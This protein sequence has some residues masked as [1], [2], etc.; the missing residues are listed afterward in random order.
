[1]DRLED[2][3]NYMGD[4]GDIV[5]EYAVRLS[6]LNMRVYGVYLLSYQK[7]KTTQHQR[8]PEDYLQSTH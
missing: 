7:G 1:M 5:D 8:S 3:A 6:L 4:Y 2:I